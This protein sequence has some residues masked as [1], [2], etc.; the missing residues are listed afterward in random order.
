M[1]RT[2]YFQVNGQLL[3]VYSDRTNAM[4]EAFEDPRVMSEYIAR[5][6]AEAPPHLMYHYTD[7][8]GLE[9]ILRS[10]ALWLTDVF[11]L[12]DPG[13]IRYGLDAACAHLAAEAGLQDASDIEKGFA[14]TVCEKLQENVESSASYFVT[15]CTFER[16]HADQ[17]RKYGDNGRGYAL[18]FDAGMLEHHFVEVAPSNHS[19]FPISYAVEEMQAMQHAIVKQG[20]EIVRAVGSHMG[21]P[22]LR[23]ISVRLSVNILHCAIFFKAPKWASER[24]YRFM[25]VHR[26]DIAVPGMKTRRRGEME[27]RYC[28]YDWKT[29]CAA[30][31]REIVL[32][33]KA[34][35][36]F[37]ERLCS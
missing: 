3:E 14:T 34:D 27:V 13:E 28:E 37:A 33:P 25:M 23:R 30:A 22:L 36:G 17:W 32:G 29:G 7:A 35:A 11:R 8:S 26:R 1:A 10:G 19:T 5:V 18:A 2:R 9:S 12:N 16:D 6:N 31:L 24:E 15:S 20:L 4:M 21:E